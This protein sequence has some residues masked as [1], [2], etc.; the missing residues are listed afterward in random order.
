MQSAVIIGNLDGVHRGH[1]AVLRQARALADARRLTT[2]VLTFDPHPSQ[3]LRGITPPRL[4][5]LERRVELLRR[6]GADEVVVEPFTPE[7][8]ALTPSR[9]VKELLVERLGARA[10]VVGENFR[11]GAKRAGDLDALRGFG[12]ELGF[13]VAAAEVAGDERGPFSSTRVRDAIGGGD[14]DEATRLLGRRHSISGVVE[15]GDRRGRTIGFP[16]ANLGGVVEVLPPHGVYAVF[17]GDRP[18]VMNVGVRPTVDG[19]SL[20]VEVHLFDFDGDLYGQSMR[21]HLVSRIRDEKKFAGI[22]ELRAQIA[23]DAEAARR[24]LASARPG[25]GS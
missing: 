16:T 4:A 3:V 12:A 18:G 7:L 21:V 14:L 25:D 6:H 1:Q 2:L 17:A 8:A 23:L 20:R 19:T 24:V 15:A 13:E 22:D 10:V 9:F 11:F 5:T